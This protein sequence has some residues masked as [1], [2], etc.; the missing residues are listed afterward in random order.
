MTPSSNRVQPIHRIAAE[1]QRRCSTPKLA[2]P[3][4][5]TNHRN[6][7]SSGKIDLHAK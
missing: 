7:P 4:G 1:G 5:E 3:L 2:E 6:R